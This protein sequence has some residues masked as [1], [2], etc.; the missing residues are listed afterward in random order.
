MN[1]PKFKPL[2]RCD[3]CKTVDYEDDVIGCKRCGFHEMKPITFVAAPLAAGEEDLEDVLR[4][5]GFVRCDMMACN[6]GSWHARYGLPERMAEVKEAL[7]D[8]GHPLCN[9][10]G[11]LVRNALAALIAERDALAALPAATPAAQAGTFHI[12]SFNKGWDAHRSAMEDVA[13]FIGAP[14]AQPLPVTG[15]AWVMGKEQNT[16][17]V[18]GPDGYSIEYEA[19]VRRIEAAHG[20]GATPAAQALANKGAT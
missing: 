16:V 17:N 9:E 19:T 1:K 13:Q 3:F 5:N 2:M 15:S 7:S 18:P 11:N 14:A 10:N 12:E 20:I 6:C 8:A 4:R